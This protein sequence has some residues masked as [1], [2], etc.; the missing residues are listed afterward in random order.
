MLKKGIK[1][2]DKDGL[3]YIVDEKNRVLKYKPWLGDIF[4][5]LYD[6]IMENSVFPKKLGADL[7]RHYDILGKVLQNVHKQRVL[8]LAT[9][10]GSV[11][12]FLP[13]DNHYTGTDI[14]PG[15]LKRAVKNFRNAG[16]TGADF[17][18]TGAD[19]LPFEDNHFNIILCI[20]SLNFFLDIN[21]VFKEINRIS[22]AKAVFICSVPVPERNK[23]KSKIRGT[24]YSEEDLM[25]ICQENA[26]RYERIPV[27]NGSLLYFRTNL[28]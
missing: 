17:Y 23:L 14:S 11:V 20:L 10:T 24:L 21:K 1:T 27:E 9:G 3:T 22:A 16:F 7:N 8:E 28:P 26:F 5:F 2:I 18:V 19:N 13:N 25:H 15:L 4:S 12:H 6:S